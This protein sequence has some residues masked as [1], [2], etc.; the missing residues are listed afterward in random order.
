M[1]ESRVR[2]TG[3][4]VVAVAGRVGTLA[5]FVHLVLQLLGQGLRGGEP[6]RLVGL[7]RWAD[8]TRAGGAG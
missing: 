5:Q 4:L 7:H 6:G 3:L 8:S 1:K 2:G